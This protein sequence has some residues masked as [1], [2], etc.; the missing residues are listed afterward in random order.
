ML[1][2]Q[3]SLF[4]T[5]TSLAF[6]VGERLLPLLERHQTLTPKTIEKIMNQECGGQGYWVWKEAYEGVEVALILLM[7][8]KGKGM[9]LWELERVQSLC[10]TQTKRSEESVTFYLLGLKEKPTA[11]T[12]QR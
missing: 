4:P 3:L 7:L 8:Q 5:T 10:P 11:N 12:E 2:Q 9:N 1:L 6:R